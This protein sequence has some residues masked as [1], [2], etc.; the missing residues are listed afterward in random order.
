VGLLDQPGAL[1][2]AGIDAVN[3]GRRVRRASGYPPLY[4]T[5]LADRSAAGQRSTYLIARVDITRRASIGAAA[6]AATE[7]I[8][9]AL[10]QKGYR[11]TALSAADLDAALGELGA[12]LVTAPVRPDPDE[13]DVGQD[14]RQAPRASVADGRRRAAARSSVAAQVR[15]RSVRTSAGYLSTY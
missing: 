9:N 1:H 2:L 4:S 7:R 11:A 5:L 3:A 6:V 14:E 13:Q 8:I 10:L 15:W 12:G